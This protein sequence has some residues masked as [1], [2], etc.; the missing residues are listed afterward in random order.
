MGMDISG[1][2]RVVPLL[3][4]AAKVPMK[5]VTRAE[6]KSVLQTALNRTKIPAKAVIHQ[7]TERKYNNYAG[8]D[9]G[10]VARGQLPSISISPRKKNEWWLDRNAEGVR[11]F[12]LMNGNRRWSDERWAA[13]QAEEADR[14]A[15]L[16]DA[17]IEAL[18]RR[19]LPKQSWYLLAEL[20]DMRLK[21]S[22]E[23]VNAKVNKKRIQHVART[24]VEEMESVYI[25]HF[26]N[27]SRATYYAD[28]GRIISTIIRG[29][30]KYFERNLRLGV[31]QSM[32][33]I[34]KAY[35]NLLTV[36]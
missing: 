12:Y 22:P 25:I 17:V 30:V 9:I 10:P 35:P 27:T 33:K 14:K 13:Y 31:F 3:A 23:V 29:R 15:D 7:R 2:D 32:E 26:T 34:A 4:K 11:T 5:Q 8:G 16:K 21:A 18:A 36:K 24:L 1:M 28:G 6:S 20:L 19:G